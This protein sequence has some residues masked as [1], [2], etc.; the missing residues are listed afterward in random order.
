MGTKITGKLEAVSGKQVLIDGQWHTI[1]FETKYLPRDINIDVEYELDPKDP[2]VVKFMKRATPK[3]RTP[4]GYQPDNKLQSGPPQS[5]SGVGG[6]TDK[7]LSII[8]QTCIKAAAELRQGTDADVV[9]VLKI[10]AELEKWVL[11]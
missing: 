9:E 10:A 1:S 3:A 11:R 7:D 4:G 6:K 8:R 2:S 5:G